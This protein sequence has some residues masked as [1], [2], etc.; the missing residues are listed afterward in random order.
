MKIVTA[1]EMVREVRRLYHQ[2]LEENGVTP[3]TVYANILWGWRDYL[4]ANLQMT[5]R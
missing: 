1:A 4:K 5:L 3:V 2:Y